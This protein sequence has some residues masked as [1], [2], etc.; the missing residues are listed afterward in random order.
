MIYIGFS[1]QTHKILPRIICKHFR[2]CAP[3]T[4]NGDKCVLF[5]FV[6]M[7]KIV[8]IHLSTKDLNILKHYGWKFIKYNCKFDRTR[9]INYKSITCVQFTKNACRIKNKRILTPD[10]LYKYLN[11]KTPA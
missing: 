10:D 1:T 9:E 11:K 7:N 4:I 5:Q 2:H 6:R 8:K 3:I